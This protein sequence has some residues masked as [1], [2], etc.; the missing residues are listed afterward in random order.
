MQLQTYECLLRLLGQVRAGM[1]QALKESYTAVDWLASA[2]LYT[3]GQLLWAWTMCAKAWAT[4][5]GIQPVYS[6]DVTVGTVWAS[7]LIL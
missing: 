4:Q 3:Y 6:P 5:V 1:P 2:E 7:R